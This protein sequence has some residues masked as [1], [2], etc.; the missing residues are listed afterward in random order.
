MYIHFNGQCS[1]YR[2]SEKKISRD[3]SSKL[4]NFKLSA[5]NFTFYYDNLRMFSL[6]I[7]IADL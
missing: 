4:H 1:V 5:V 6:N 2:K 3:N 7:Y